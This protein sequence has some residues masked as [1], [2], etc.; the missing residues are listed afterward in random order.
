MRSLNLYAG[1]TLKIKPGQTKVVPMCFDTHAIKR[2]MNLG[3]KRRLDIDLYSRKNEKVMV[4]LKTER[5]DRLV[6]TLPAV[7]SKGTI[8][9]TAV[10]NTDIEWKIDRYQMMGSLDCRS[11]G[12]FHIS[13]HSLQRIMSDNA[14]FLNDRETVE[15]FNILVEDHKNVMKFAQETVLQRQKMEAERNT[16][17]KS[18]QSKGKKDFNDS[19]MSEDNDP[20][21]WL[22]KDDPRR[23]MTDRECLE[24]Y[25]DLSDSDITEREKKNLYKVLYKYK[26]AFSLRD[27]IG[28]CQ[29]MEVELELRDETP[30]FIRPFPIKESDKD[31]VDKEMRKGCL[32]GILKKGMSSYSS[33]IML[34]PRK[35][36]GIPRIV[37]DFRHLNSILFTLQPSIPL[38]RDAIQILGASGCEILS[39]AD[40]RDAYHTLRLSERSKKFCGITPYYGSGSYLYQR[41]GMGLSVSPAMWQ[42]F[43]QKV[44]QEIP[45]HRKNHLAI[46]DDFLVFSKK[47]DHLKHLTDLFKALIRNGLKISPRKCKL[48][49][50]SLVYMGHQVSIIDGIPHITPVKSRVDAI[51]KLDPPKSPKNSKQFCGMVNYLSMF[52]KDLQTKLIPIY[53]LTKKGVPF[54]WGELQQKA[55]EQI[56]KDL[57]EA[58]VLAMPNSEGH[59]VLA[60]DTSK[61]ACGS[62]LYQEQKGRYRLT[63]YF[64]KKLP[65]LAQRYSISEL[66]LTGI[67]ANV[68]AFKHLLRNVHF[69]LYCDHSALVH[70]M[71]GKKEPPTLR[72]KKLIENLS[73]FKFDIKFLRG[74]DMFVSDF[75]S[76]HPDSEDSCN[77]PIIPVAFLMKEIELPQHSPKFLD[78][79]NIMLDSREM[80]AY[81]ESPFKECKCERIMNMNEPFQVLTRSMAKT[82]KAD[83]PAMYPLKGDHKKP[84]KSQIGIIEVKDPEEVGQGEVQIVPNQHPDIEDNIMAE[85]DNVNIPDIVSR[86]VAQNVPKVN[87]T[88]LQVPPVLNEPIPMKP[89]K[90][91]TSVINY[92]Q[93]LTPVNIDVT[94]KGQLPPFD[95]EKSFEAIQTSVEQYPDLES[96]FREDKP[97]FK[98]GTEISL[99]MKHIP[100][101]KQLEKF[102]NYLKQ[103]VIHD[104]EVP[105]SVKELK[106]EYHVDPY[107]KD[108]V[109]YLEK[110][111]CRY[112]GKA[113]T[114]FKMQCEDYV[115]VNGVLFK[116]RYGKEDKGEPSLVLCIPEKYIPTVLYQYHTPLLAGHPGVIKLYDTIK[117]R[118]YF[119]GMFN[120]VREFVECCLECQ[121]MKGKTDGPR[122]QYARIPLDT[123]TMARMSMDI[124]EMPESELGFRQIL[125]CVCEFTNWMKTIPLADQKAQTIAMALNF[126]IC[127]EYDTPKAIICDEAPAFQSSALQEYFKALNIQPI[128]MTD[129]IMSD[130]HLGENIN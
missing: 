98:P 99:F 114:V 35:L 15:Y 9:L 49:K 7:M 101:Q 12:Y 96:L 102:V 34:I 60:S 109:K 41:L 89:V 75:L 23:N 5:K 88:G 97:L 1:D 130:S 43:I 127:C 38:V 100:K 64:S 113:Q 78:W 121:S 107:F 116:I 21:P 55:F 20:Y 110:D 36:S 128:V 111:Y 68:L 123:R 31:I 66:E 84:E 83:V 51:V 129:N 52:L 62:A 105:L 63:A 8:F 53:H 117:Q 47:Y 69:T 86:P 57:T 103:R 56:K 54:H 3:E 50:T 91:A 71:N 29:S 17:L 44:L 46:M 85:I 95:M 67:Y 24:N 77:D 45:N 18:R 126:K 30:F 94:L 125:V 42:N 124:K 4:N 70:I 93:I 2:D 48:F 59:M 120:L 76:R 32:L 33:P 39:L 40:L 115:L 13:R 37:T 16:Q 74:K 61:I 11:L 122:I 79:L 104:C 22:D 106:A 87:M 14:N 28:L 27:E 6:Q 92:D 80:V 108:I 25:I 19:N 10:N 119:P 82:V 112:V 65:L 72:L 118:Y 73:D 81:K 90:K 26:K 58:P